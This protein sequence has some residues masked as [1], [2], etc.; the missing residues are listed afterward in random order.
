MSQNFA[1]PAHHSSQEELMLRAVYVIEDL[2]KRLPPTTD[3]KGNSISVTP[4]SPSW[5]KLA[6]NQA[7]TETDRQHPYARILVTAPGY[8]IARY[9]AHAD[10]FRGAHVFP[11]K[12]L[13]RALTP[14][15]RNKTSVLTVGKVSPFSSPGTLQFSRVFLVVGGYHDRWLR[16][17]RDRL[18]LHTL[19]PPS[20]ARPAR[21]SPAILLADPLARRSSSRS[22]TRADSPPQRDQEG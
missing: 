8:T 7:L 9:C 20:R 12:L 17:P 10:A 11:V 22:S 5:E 21:I 4:G 14:G 18:S 3:A 6:V 1:R 19:S 2:L 13:R 16:R 15:S